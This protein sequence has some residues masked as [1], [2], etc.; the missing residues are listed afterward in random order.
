MHDLPRIIMRAL[1]AFL[2]LT[3]ADELIFEI[4]TDEI[5]SLLM[6]EKVT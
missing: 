5:E 2:P 6:L 4:A 3:T 1:A